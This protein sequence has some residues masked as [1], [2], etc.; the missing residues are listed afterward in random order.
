MMVSEVT[1]V[2]PVAVPSPSRV[3]ASAAA[4]AA[5]ASVRLGVATSLEVRSS[6]QAG[7][8]AAGVTTRTRYQMPVKMLHY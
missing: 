2:G 1:R 4:D 6:S 8:S 3:S 5:V 7:I